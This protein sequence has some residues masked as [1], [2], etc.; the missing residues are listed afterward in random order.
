MVCAVTI[1]IGQGLVGLPTARVSSSTPSAMPVV[2]TPIPNRGM[3]SVLTPLPNRGKHS[4]HSRRSRRADS[5]SG[6]FY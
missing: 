2:L 6:K 5:D 4:R 1:L 3:P